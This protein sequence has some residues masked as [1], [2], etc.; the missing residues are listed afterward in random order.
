MLWTTFA[1][2]FDSTDPRKRPF[3]CHCFLSFVPWG[4][5]KHYDLFMVLSAQT[6]TWFWKHQ[7]LMMAIGEVI[8]TDTS[9]WAITEGNA[10]GSGISYNALFSPLR[11]EPIVLFRWQTYKFQTAFHLT[12]STAIFYCNSS[13]S[14]KCLFSKIFFETLYINS[15]CTYVEAS[16]IDFY[17]T[18][19]HLGQREGRH[20]KGTI[21]T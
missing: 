2:L 14:Q 15:K 19:Q 11:G 10:L 4:G 12:W 9:W 17:K 20:A 13:A 18:K 3:P 8:L 16:P 7:S 5:S 1:P 6:I 21:T